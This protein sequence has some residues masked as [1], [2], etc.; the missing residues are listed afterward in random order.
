MRS[1]RRSNRIVIEFYQPCDCDV[2]LLVSDYSG[3]RRS[4]VRPAPIGFASLTRRPTENSPRNDRT[5]LTNVQY[6]VVP[7]APL[8][9]IQKAAQVEIPQILV[10]KYIFFCF[11]VYM[12]FR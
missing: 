8:N 1:I 3:C 11:A 5:H 7:L 6:D 4:N 10:I 9:D 2:A 12:L